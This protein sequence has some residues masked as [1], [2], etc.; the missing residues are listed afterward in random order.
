MLLML[1]QK[2]KKPLNLSLKPSKYLL[3]FIVL[4]HLLAISVLF[5][6]LDIH[7]ILKIIL[8]VLV[9]ISLY[10][11][12]KKSN[13]IAFQNYIKNIEYQKDM[14]WML[15]SSNQKLITA[16][17]QQNWFV[18]SWLVILYFKIDSNKN[19]ITIILPDMIEKNDFRLLKL[20]LRQIR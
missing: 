14:Q 1:S 7:L 8:F 4:I 2:Y 10:L 16:N 6:N 5:L 3:Y 12:L 19:I 18:L 9:I 11:N 13:S 17:L 15:V 20:H